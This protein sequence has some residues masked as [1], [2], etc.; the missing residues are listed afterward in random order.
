[1]TDLSRVRGIVF[2]LDGTL[3]DG[4][5]GITTA[6]NAARAAARLPPLSPETVTSHVGRGLEDLLASTLPEGEVARGL[7]VFRETYDRVGASESV[8]MP[9]AADVLTELTGRGFRLAVASNKLA[10]FSIRILETLG[11]AA[12]F[13]AIH[14]PDSAG[15]PKPDPA[16]IDACLAAMGIGREDAIYVGDMPLDVDAAARAGLGVVLLAGG[17]SPREALERTG[18]TVLGG[19]RELAASLPQRPR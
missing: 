10:S 9:G 5:Q 11:L 1:V 14:G 2:D 19:L 12:S 4:F 8:A 6:V 16:M 15:R 13:D 3:V 17:A 7:V 18:A